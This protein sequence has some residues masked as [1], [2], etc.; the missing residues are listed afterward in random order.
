MEW[1]WCPNILDVHSEYWRYM[2]FNK[3]MVWFENRDSLNAFKVYFL[4]NL[5]AAK[6]NEEIL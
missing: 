2:S 1:L 3:G 6:K 4:M 5:G